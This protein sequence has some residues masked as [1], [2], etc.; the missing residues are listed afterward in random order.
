MS[1]NL[2][3]QRPE[4]KVTNVN[5]VVLHLNDREHRKTFIFDHVQ[6]DIT[7]KTG[8]RLNVKRSV[9]RL[10]TPTSRFTQICQ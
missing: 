9:T 5:I 4:F 6:N 2:L 8:G 10:L 1:E 3:L 7:F